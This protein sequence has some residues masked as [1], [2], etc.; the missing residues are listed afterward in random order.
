MCGQNLLSTGSF[1]RLISQAG[2]WDICLPSWVFCA[3]MLKYWEMS[4]MASFG[5]AALRLRSG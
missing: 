2:A 4:L 1:A 5:R 3:S